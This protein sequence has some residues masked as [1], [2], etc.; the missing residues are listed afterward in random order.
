MS[1][2]LFLQ[3]LER[4]P[5]ALSLRSLE[6]AEIAEKNSVYSVI[7]AC[8]ACP[9]EYEVHSSGVAPEDGTGVRDLFNTSREV[10]TKSIFYQPQ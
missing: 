2:F 9:V 5:L 3:S 4:I 7:S 10:D 8:P 6:F 1:R